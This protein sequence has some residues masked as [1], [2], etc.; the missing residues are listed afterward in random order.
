[1]IALLLLACTGQPTDTAVDTADSAEVQG[2]EVACALGD[3]VAEWF[4]G[5]LEGV[6]VPTDLGFCEGDEPC[7]LTDGHRVEAEIHDATNDRWLSGYEKI[8]NDAD[9]STRAFVLVRQES[10]SYDACRITL[11]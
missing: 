10:V 5:A 7:D 6:R 3:P 4:A 1:V 8:A 9:D 2:V 11:Y